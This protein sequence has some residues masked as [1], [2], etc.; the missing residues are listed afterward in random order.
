MN[1]VKVYKAVAQS[2]SVRQAFSKSMLAVHLPTQWVDEQG[3][4]KGDKLEVTVDGDWI[5]VRKAKNDESV[6]ESS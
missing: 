1:F 5:K 3:I 4:V 6:T 2:G